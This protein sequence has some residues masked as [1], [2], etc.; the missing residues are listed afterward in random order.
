MVPVKP[1]AAA[2]KFTVPAPWVKFVSS[3]SRVT[4]HTAF[5]SMN[6]TSVVPPETVDAPFH[7]PFIEAVIEPPL[8]DT[9]SPF[10][11]GNW[12]YWPER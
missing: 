6:V 5:A 12:A 9:K 11:V 1:E 7:L 10:R 2:G 8:S 4:F 3:E